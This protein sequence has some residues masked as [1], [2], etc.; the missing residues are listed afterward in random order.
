MRKEAFFLLSACALAGCSVNG[1]KL[2]E[3]PE[4]FT[5]EKKL[6]DAMRAESEYQMTGKVTDKRLSYI[7]PNARIKLKPTPG[8]ETTTGPGVEVLTSMKSGGYFA[9]V[10]EMPITQYFSIVRRADCDEWGTYLPISV[11]TLQ[12]YPEAIAAGKYKKNKPWFTCISSF[13]E[14]FS[15]GYEPLKDA[16]GAV[17]DIDSVKVNEN[18]IH[19]SLTSNMMKI[20]MDGWAIKFQDPTHDQIVE[21]LKFIPSYKSNIK[22]KQFSTVIYWIEKNKETRYVDQLLSLLPT[23]DPQRSPFYWNEQDIR[24]LHALAKIAPDAISDDFWMGVIEKGRR[25]ELDS[26]T[27]HTG[28]AGSAPEIAAN[29]LVCKKNNKKELIARFSGVLTGTYPIEHKRAAAE[30]LY[31]LNVPEIVEK[32]RLSMRLNALLPYYKGV[33][34]YKCP[35]SRLTDAS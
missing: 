21:H 32:S 14:H 6:R 25:P 28:Y 4:V 10:Q 19:W 17:F 24:I 8:M 26:K 18:A 7:D 13:D 29:V 33:S 30:A 5:E 27:P 15:R 20:L 1:Q 34:G 3:R 22:Q 31:A 16:D 9:F 12:L 35:Y 2:G 11:K 23:R